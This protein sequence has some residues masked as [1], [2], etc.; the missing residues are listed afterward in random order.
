MANN[1]AILLFEK[2]ISSDENQQLEFIRRI[3][4]I[5]TSFPQNWIISKF[6]PFLVNWLPKNNEKMLLTLIQYVPQFITTVGSIEISEPLIEA[7]LMSENQEIEK[8]LISPLLQF[9]NDPTCHN[10]IE[11]LTSSPYDSVRSFVPLI[12]DLAGDD[13]G[14]REILP[15]LA[16]D[17]SFRVRKASLQ[18]TESIA[19]ED[20]ACQL[21]YTFMNDTHSQI[22][23]HIPIVST[24]RPF[25][26]VHILPKLYEDPDWSVRASVARELTKCTDTE[27][28]IQY[29]ITLAA[30]KV[31]QVR[32][33][34]LKSLS[35]LLIGS[36]SSAVIDQDF[37]NLLIDTIK[38]P[39]PSL[40]K[41]VIDFFLVFFTKPS[42]F[43]DVIMNQDPETKM[44][45]LTKVIQRK[46]LKL[47]TQTPNQLFEII[48]DITKSEKW[49]VRKAAVEIF[50]DIAKNVQDQ[51]TINQ[52]T[53]LAMSLLKDEAAPVRESAAIQLA[54]FTNCENI[55]QNF[56]QFLIELEESDYFR[57]RQAALDLL[58][59]LFM[60]ASSQS[61]KEFLI[62]HIRKFTRDPVHNVVEYANFILN[63]IE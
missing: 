51:E 31:W 41:C 52:L 12:I 1:P 19:N 17:S 8:Q 54:A 40:K 22:R 27:S 44:Y 18:I 28:A 16:Y 56:P 43:A 32:F 38:F 50:I 34:A 15:S 39:D 57:H 7:L 2:A 26:K 61:T 37:F 30:D 63:K 4:D 42:T 6:L 29:C 62:S 35:A 5:L 48:K 20:L 46:K 14:K 11:L 53:E 23:A 3:P 13:D 58:H 36:K 59:A 10:F 49:S 21:A 47:L 24:H 60:K 25:Y 9:K 33:F 55:E 45:F